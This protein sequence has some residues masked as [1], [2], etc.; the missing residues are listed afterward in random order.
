M[1][2][3]G[4]DLRYGLYLLRKHPGFA[5]VAIA[6]LAFGIGANTVLFSAVNAALFRPTHAERP[7]ELVSLFNG[8]R[9]RQGT[10]NHSYPSFVDLRNGTAEA[11]SG[12]AAYTT[13]PVNLI[14]GQHV[15][16]INVGLVSA[17]YL[18]VLGVRPVAGRAFLPEE[19]ATPGAHAVALIS[20]GLWR[21]RFGAAPLRGDQQVWLANRP[22]TVVGVVPDAAARMA[23]IV[24]IDVFVPIMMQGAIRGGRDY[25]S[26]R[27][28]ADFMLIGRLRPGMTLP[29][30]QQSVDRLIQRLQDTDPV[31]WTT[32]E[33]R[34]RPMTVVSEAESRGLFELRGWVIGFATL[35]MAAVC[36][37]LMMA[38]A[39]LANVLLARGLARRHELTVRAA[40]GASRRRLVRQL[41]TETF[42][43][44]GLGGFG[45]FLVA[46][47]VKELLRVFEPNIGVPLSIDLS[48]DARVFAFSAAVTLLAMVASGLAPALQV[49]SPQLVS[50]LQEGHRTTSGGRRVS[51]LSRLLLVAQVAVSVLLVV[52]AA[53]L[54]RGLTRLAAIDLGFDQTRIA[55]L[56]VDLAMHDDASERRRT[57][58]DDALAQVREVPGVTA[59]AVAS[60]LPLG[61]NRTN[62]TL[63]PEGHE[64]RPDQ[65][66]AFGFN[67][68]SPDYF[69][70]MGIPLLIGRAFTA[71][72]RAEGP[73]V[74][75]VNEN[76]ARRYWPAGEAIGK[77]LYTENG[78]ALEIVG[79]VKG[80]TYD[81]LMQDPQPFVYLPLAQNG[82][83]ALTIHARTTVPPAL[84]LEDLRRKLTAIDPRLPV[85]DV[86]TMDEHVAVPLL[87]IR[88]GASLLGLFGAVALGLASIG[89]YGALASFVSQRTREIGVRMALG[90]PRRKIFRFVL[91]QGVRPLL[92]GTLLGLLPCV[93]LALVAVIEVFRDER[94][95][96][97]DIA[98][99]GGILAVQMAVALLVCWIPARRAVR[100]DPVVALRAD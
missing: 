11:L 70:V 80:S 61:F 15:E 32:P 21:Q 67:R 96:L 57:F 4:Q 74:A 51:R 40:L 89:L 1:E 56:S 73:R 55:L 50:N 42:A 49:T 16:R 99:I 33:G 64:F 63:L 87:P 6:T 19:D 66:P 71:Q 82:T 3:L 88:M 60:R 31:S 72:D 95:P 85:F 13:R 84:L 17:N 30:A 35:L 76:L 86:K 28:S 2:T 36:A 5:I 52:G 75:I 46:L 58:V 100:L 47:W 97:G 29:R 93:T 94:V 22:Y 27:G 81:T 59:A 9:D 23:L 91:N 54:L 37:V 20:E 24:K 39:N 38:C 26:E 34:L 45:G 90:A 14:L 12:L 44:A 43:I 25:L 78:Q 77:R 18:N 92:W 79:V 10:S 98:F 8:G 83:A 7:A 69:R 62:V 53:L 65:R 68:I 41:L 48:L